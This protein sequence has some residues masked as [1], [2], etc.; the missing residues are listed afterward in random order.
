MIVIA[1][2]LLASQS[3]GAGGGPGCENFCI[4]P[5]G[6]AL[7]GAL[8]GVGVHCCN[9]HLPA[10][11]VVGASAGSG[12]ALPIV[13]LCTLGACKAGETCQ[14]SFHK[15]VHPADQSPTSATMS[16][17]PPPY[18]NRLVNG[19]EKPQMEYICSTEGTEITAE[20]AGPIGTETGTY[21]DTAQ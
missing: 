15:S 1:M 9:P 14:E 7:F 18:S 2:N 6:G 17:P 3:F 12:A 19:A 20:D 8:L 21:T 10:A 5:V 13:F 4:A 11:T 16:D